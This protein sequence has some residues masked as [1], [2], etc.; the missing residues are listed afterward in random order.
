LS[1]K[2]RSIKRAMTQKQMKQVPVKMIP[3][4]APVMEQIEK[5]CADMNKERGLLSKAGEEPPVQVNSV[6]LI[7]STMAQAIN[8][9]WKA[10][11]I[12]A[13]KDNVIQ[14]AGGDVAQKLKAQESKV[15][16]DGPPK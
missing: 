9:Y 1:N 4:F 8:E 2:I 13:G 7:N 11:K 12:A 16:K 5:I 6:S 15:F 3:I 10:K 14:I